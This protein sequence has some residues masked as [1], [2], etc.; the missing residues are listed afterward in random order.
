MKLTNLG[1]RIHVIHMRIRIARTYAM[2]EILFEKNF[3]THSML[4]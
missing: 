3:R 4:V 2:K 1:R